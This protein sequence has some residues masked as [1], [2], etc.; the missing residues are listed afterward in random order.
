VDLQLDNNLE[1]P[2]SIFS[3]ENGGGMFLQ[4]IGVYLL[5]HNPEQHCKLLMI[6]TK[7]IWLLPVALVQT[8]YFEKILLFNAKSLTCHM[9]PATLEMLMVTH[10][11]RNS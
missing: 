3:S 8:A 10:L 2:V 1:K 6:L 4:N 9:E 11:S 5:H 7:N